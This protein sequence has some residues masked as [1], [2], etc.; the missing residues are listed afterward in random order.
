MK[1]A[2]LGFGVEGQ[3]VSKYFLSRGDE[4]RVFSP[5]QP[6]DLPGLGLDQFDLVFRSPSLHPPKDTAENWTSVTKY[7]FDRCPCQIIGVT[8][9]KGKGTTCSMISALLKRLVPDRKVHL[10]GN[11]GL[12]ALDV[13]DEVRPEDTV[14]Y[15]LSSF[16]LWDLQKSPSVAVVLRVE[17]DHLDVH[18][19]F[20]D[21]VAAK[22][23]IAKHQTEN[24][25]IIYYS[26]NAESAKIAELS[27]GQKLQYPL[28]KDDILEEILK[29]L[30]VQGE[31]NRENAEAALLAVF[32]F[33]EREHK[34]SEFLAD[35][36]ETLKAGLADF[37]GLPHRLEFIKELNKVKYYDDSF[38]SALP[39]ME[40]AIKTFRGTPTVLIAGGKDR[41]LDLSEHKRA[42]FYSSNV[43][44]AILIGETREKL[45]E[46]EDPEKYEF[47][48]SLEEAVAR[49][50][51]KAEFLPEIFDSCMYDKEIVQKP[52]VVLLSPGAPS[53]DMF[54]DFKDR[55]EQFQK[56]VRGFD[57]R[58]GE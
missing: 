3:S 34:F 49:A 43:K 40:V 33:L 24:D 10:V 51:E 23:N 16:Q 30:R 1:I 13:L 57:N 41:G 29:G 31:H 14:V 20:S 2:I 48:D 9:T 5:V 36:A 7:F 21:Y 52:A 25:S 56:L 58:Q 46:G 27:P 53:F 28:L 35:H 38:S 6:E 19:D 55:G 15:E 18:D 42:I 44:Y 32:A 22:S 50:R 54:K 4:V 26:E 8:G 39:A 12:P 47:A 45:A 17:P 11:I 37:P